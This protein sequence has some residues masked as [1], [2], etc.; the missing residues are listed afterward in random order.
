MEASKQLKPVAKRKPPAAGR[1]RKKGE[2]NKTTRALK[3]AIM[4]AFETI[5]GE[6]YLVMVAREDPRTFCTL[7]GKVLPMQV[8][9]TGDDGKIKVEIEWASRGS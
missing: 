4:N 2:L 7:L 8:E 9:G 5:G 3:D 6:S 1:G